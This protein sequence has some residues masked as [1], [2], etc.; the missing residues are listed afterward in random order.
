[1]VMT[2][3]YLLE[4]NI[5]IYISKKSPLEVFQRLTE[6][7]VGDVGMSMVTL[8]E[9]L[10]GAHKSQHHEIALEKLNQLMRYIR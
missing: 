8:G 2:V 5:C 10:F 4:T 6:R 7:T 1:M 3:A 9:L